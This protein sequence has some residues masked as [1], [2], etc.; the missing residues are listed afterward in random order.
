MRLD[1]TVSVERLAK[2]VRPIGSI[3]SRRP[4]TSVYL[5]QLNP[6]IEDDKAKRR[7]AATPGI[8]PLEPREEPV[9]LSSVRSLDRKI[10]HLTEEE[11]EE[12]RENGGAKPKHKKDEADYLRAYRYFVGQR[13]FPNDRVDWAA[14]SRAKAQSA[15]MRPTAFGGSRNG[16]VPLESQNWQYV[17]PTNLRVPYAQYYGISPVNGR[18][19]AVAFDPINSQILYAGAAQGGLWKSTDSGATWNWLSSSWS[20]LGVNCIAIDPS[21]PST[22][23][24]GLGDYHGFLAGSNGI[25]KS[26]DGGA[27]W[28]E[29]GRTAM[30]NVGVDSL[31]ID[32]TNPQTIM[33]GTGDINNYGHMYRSTDG[34]Q[35]WTKLTTG[36]N[37]CE[38]PSIVSSASSNGNVRFYSVASG[39]A[40]NAGA[41][42]RLYKSD[43]HGAT[44]QV[45][46]SPVKP[47]GTFQYAFCLT[48]SPTNP[49]NVYA[50]QSE[51]QAFYTSTNQGASWTSQ[52]SNLPGGSGNY[53]FS[54][55]FYDYHLECGTRVTNGNS[56]D[57]LF[58]GEI[59]ITYSLNGGVSWTTIGGP[60]YSS[61]GAI[62]HNDQHG[63][64]ICPTDPNKAIF[65]N[66]GGV[67][68]LA[69][70]PGL[71][72]YV[73]TPLNKNL[74]VSMFYKIA[75]HPTNPDYI[76]GGT[77]D[78]ASP[79]STGDLSNWLNVGGGDG[80][81]SAIN[82]TSP[83]IQYTTS[84]SMTVYRT[85]D[86]WNTELDI[87]PPTL[88]NENLPFVAAMTL[89]PSNQSLMYTATNYLYQ[90]NEN[91]NPT[92]WST[93]LGNQN[94]TNASSSSTVVQAIAVAPTDGKRIYTGSDDG[95]LYMTTDRG[96]TWTHL[97]P[98][99]G[100]LPNHA[101]TSINVSP[102][103]A[104][105]ILIGFSG[106]GQNTAHLIRCSNT[107][108]S[109]L[110]FTN[111]AGTG[112]SG[113]PDIALNAIER[114]L[115]NPATTWWVALDSGVL[116]TTDSGQTW[117][118]AGATRGLPNVIIDDLVAVPGTRYLNAGTYGRG[119]WR[120]LLNQ[121]SPVA[122][123]V[124][125]TLNSPSIAPGGT[126]I[127]TVT[128]SSAA[129]AGGLV[130]TLS[131]SNTSQVT[132][133]E[134]VTVLAG[135]TT[136]TFTVTANP[137]AAG[138]GSSVVSATLNSITFTQD[139]AVAIP[140]LSTLTISP[141]SVAG[142]NTATGTVTLTAVAPSPTTV[143]LTSSK[144]AVVVP[145][146]VIVPAG[147]ATGTFTITTTPVTLST[148]GTVSAKLGAVTKSATLT[149][150]PISIQSIGLSPTL[151]VGGSQ[152]SVTATVTL[153][154][155]APA[156]GAKVILSS[157]RPTVA[158]VP[159]SITVP[160]GSSTATFTV[161]HLAVT[162]TSA[163][164]I[165]ATYGGVST[166]AVLTVN[167]L[168]IVSL[169]IAPTSLVGGNSATGTVT[170]NTSLGAKSVT[171][172]LLSNSLK[173]KVPATVIIPAGGTTASF[174][175][176]TLAVPA[177]LLATVTSTLGASIQKATLAIQA[178][179]LVSVSLNPT[180]VQGVSTTKVTGTVTI[181]SPAPVGG[182]LITLKSSNTLAATVL[183]S[184]TVPVGKLTGT[185]VVAHKKVAAQ[186]TVTI[187]A[188]RSGIIQTASL[189]VT[190]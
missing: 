46:A 17:G 73:V 38:W 8:H 18:V 36:G 158:S 59:D 130:V 160:A 98:V 71:N 142:G 126:S 144:V 188:T 47:D 95:A 110:V 52:S 33:A 166:T 117:T 45:L 120:L 177:N 171:V 37:D 34:G 6:G 21:S 85:S 39:Y 88:Q 9:D 14:F 172:K 159:A 10:A 67:Y 175:A 20:E 31:L 42:S 143:A 185:F 72:K 51:S 56:A 134:S 102:Y 157:T 26:S 168:Q 174:S 107:T 128:L 129:P 15:K 16:F 125:C 100:T 93:R 62:S 11:K 184:V 146:T 91:G 89:D 87:S 77:Q 32:P 48:T 187:T 161:T 136:A 74:G 183:A 156:G 104:N 23:Y 55:S 84:E 103:N 12:R 119:M 182:L 150:K 138:A 28:T 154:G 176:T 108:A 153:L 173:A 133:P 181:S 111:V 105:D 151:V 116:Q 57:V 78:N 79:L 145:S 113:I 169:S 147:S 114:D 53:N 180:T 4:G 109:K 178:P 163:A 96:Q 66:D 35:T 94:L 3:E 7:L 90:W 80:G 70:D 13:A 29:I 118:N 30:G 149:V 132:V 82:Q 179:T 92:K 155:V 58:L 140:T 148:V 124:N 41:T 64:A 68:G 19:N 123:L 165:K 5:I 75:M 65:S 61:F 40:R 60:T 141:T 99:T 81:G 86:G 2:A 1:S 101:I 137:N 22:I 190:P 43:D 170:L 131:S 162:I 139:I 49:N 44:W 127:G 50:L 122:S 115:D 152:T 54:Q 167:P 24:V 121:T 69:Y 189:T 106:T 76:L 164:T 97:N 135:S 112:T 25:M 83:L 63:L 186:A 27:T